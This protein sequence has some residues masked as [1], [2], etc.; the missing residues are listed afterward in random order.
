M[1]RLTRTPRWQSDPNSVPAFIHDVCGL[2][3]V[4]LLV[5]VAA[6]VLA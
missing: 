4:A 5:A 2:L 6:M 1:N 3:S